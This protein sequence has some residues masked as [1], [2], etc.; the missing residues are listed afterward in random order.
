MSPDL[1]VASE[2]LSRCAGRGGAYRLCLYQRAIEAS[3]ELKEVIE[4]TPQSIWPTI[5]QILSKLHKLPFSKQINYETD[6]LKKLST[7][8]RTRDESL[9]VI[10]RAGDKLHL[11]SYDP[12]AVQA[13]QELGFI[14]QLDT[15]FTLICYSDFKRIKAELSTNDEDLLEQILREGKSSRASDVHIQPRKEQTDI[16]FRIDGLLHPWRSIPHP[17]TTT[18][19][20]RIKV[21][22]DLDITQHRHP[23][24]GR[25]HWHNQ[26]IRVSI[27]PTIWGEKVVL[28]MQAEQ[29]VPSLDKL[30]LMDVQLD[31]LKR[32]LLS[33]H[34]LLLV[35]GPTGSGKSLTLYSCLKQLQTPSLSICTVEDPVEIQDTNYNQIQIDPNINYGFAEALRSILRQDP[36]I[37]MLGEIRDSES[38]DRH[39]RS[40]NRSLSPLYSAHQ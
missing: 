35:T 10:N 14:H 28:R 36:D 38:A 4:S 3:L 19:V 17:F 7:L 18:L 21:L 27:L 20:S 6:E 26:D 12:K 37:I 2:T 25:L 24:D 40:S 30:G 23:Q 33:P 9:I 22:A 34:G 1:K 32:T 11:V 29:Q 39:T 5:G 13:C 16:R 15:Q 31:H 8:Y